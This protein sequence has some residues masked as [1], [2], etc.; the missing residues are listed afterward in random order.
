VSDPN[1]VTL[2]GGGF[3]IAQSLLLNVIALTN[4][5]SIE[6]PQE[7][8]S[9]VTNLFVDFHPTTRQRTVDVHEI[10]PIALE[11]SNYVSA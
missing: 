10:G 2:K 4:V 5:G 11:S 9:L 7:Y 6:I 3:N 8:R 1:R